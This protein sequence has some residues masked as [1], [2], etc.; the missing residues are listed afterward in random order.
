MIDNR[1][2]R[3][4]DLIFETPSTLGVDRTSDQIRVSVL[5]SNRISSSCYLTNLLSFSITSKKYKYF[6]TI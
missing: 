1:G 2:G 4:G 3:T 6:N 5:F